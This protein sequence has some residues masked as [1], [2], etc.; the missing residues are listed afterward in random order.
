[1]AIN[2]DSKDAIIREE[3][4]GSTVCWDGD[5]EGFAECTA[6]GGAQNKERRFSQAGICPNGCAAGNLLSIRDA[7][8][9]MH[10]PAGCSHV[11]SATVGHQA[12]SRIN[13]RYEAIGYGDD[14]NEN[15]TIFG[16][17]DNL[18]AMAVEVIESRKPAAL[19]IVNSC[20]SAIIGED[21]DSLV[22]ELKETYDLPIGT[23]NCEGFKS[24]VWFS[25][26]DATFHTL[27]NTLVKEPQEKRDVVN[28][29]NFFESE[30]SYLTDI[31]GR[32][33]VTLQFLV[34]NSS[35]DEISHIGESRA[36]VSVCSTLGTYLGHAL[37]QKFDVP[38]LKTINPMGMTGFDTWFRGIAEILDKK[39]EAEEIIRQERA[40]YLPKIEEIKKKTTGLKAV[41]AMGA[42]YSWEMARVLQEL[43]IEILSLSAGHYDPRQDGDNIPPA[44]EYM[45]ENST[46]NFITNVSD[47]QNFEVFNIIHTL[48]PDVFFSRHPGFTV[49]ATKQNIP[50]VYVGDEY[51]AL[52]YK[53]TLALANMIVD[54]VTNRSFETNLAT[55]ARLP[56]TSW[57]LNQQHAAMHKEA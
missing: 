9:I 42:G 30:R 20:A 1:M 56:Y 16:S 5:L 24:Q 49:W 15:D 40:K 8:V 29:I 33:G 7:A 3:R 13:A 39:D 19:F 45:T 38:F 31:F 6:C 21:I 47:N 14:M 2:L 34:V 57:W 28:F 44:I 26:V 12:A 17:I 27:V 25:G 11:G 36:T 54:A 51:L 50:A 46:S 4:L 41:L 10:G 43:G 37:E 55:H 18:K 53:G 35:V 32:L 48:K 23:V 22:S 52:G